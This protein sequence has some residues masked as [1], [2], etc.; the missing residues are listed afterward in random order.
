MTQA[1]IKPKRIQ[2]QPGSTKSFISKLSKGLMLPIAL[3]PI[4]GLFLGIGA[5]VQNVAASMGVTTGAA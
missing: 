3:L 5:G 1:I 2:A 4:A